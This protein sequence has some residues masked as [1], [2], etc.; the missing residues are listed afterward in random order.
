[1]EVVETPVA[2]P[3]GL[4]HV[5]YDPPTNQ[6]L[7]SSTTIVQMFHHT[8]TLSRLNTQGPIEEFSLLGSSIDD[9]SDQLEQ[10]ILSCHRDGFA[11][12]LLASTWR[13]NM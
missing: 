2:T 5:T 1:M 8:S 13:F 3:Q 6:T 12:R 10:V 9:L 4:W 7:P 11:D